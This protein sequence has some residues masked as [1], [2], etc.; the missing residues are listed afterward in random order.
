MGWDDD[1]DF[2]LRRAGRKWLQGQENEEE[3]N[4]HLFH[5]LNR[6][7][8]RATDDDKKRHAEIDS[9]LEFDRFWN[10]IREKFGLG[11][12]APDTQEKMRRR[13]RDKEP[14]PAAKQN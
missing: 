14:Q 4:G 12:Y 11:F 10:C 1:A 8:R 6:N 9:Q 3:K 5:R 7:L 2:E 13:K